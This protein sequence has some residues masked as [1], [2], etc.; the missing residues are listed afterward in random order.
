MTPNAAARATLLYPQEALQYEDEGDVVVDL[1]FSKPDA[2]PRVSEVEGNN[3]NSKP[4]QRAVR[5]HVAAFRVP[6]L[7]EP[8]TLRQTYAFTVNDGRKLM[9]SQLSERTVEGF[10]AKQADAC[11]AHTNGEQQPHYSEAAQYANSQDT[12]IV[13]LAFTAADQPPQ[14][15]FLASDDRSLRRITQKFVQ[16]LRVPCLPAGSTVTLSRLFV[17]R[18]LESDRVFLN[19]QTLTTFL[20]AVQNLPP[21]Q[22]NLDAMACPF[23]V[24][25]T[26][27]QPYLPNHI[28]EIAT[29]DPRRKPFLTWLSTLQLRLS[30]EQRSLSLGRSM[31]VT[32][33]CGSINL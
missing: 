6:C 23:D 1:A 11:V 2:P 14:V 7:K 4:L 10:S 29:T 13:R 24:R 9:P 16:G 20:A 26:P 3:P 31:V 21:A 12:Q 17:Y 19:D 5:K 32:V 30:R 18:L 28:N 8:V 33:P 15:E 25:I 22:F 27:L